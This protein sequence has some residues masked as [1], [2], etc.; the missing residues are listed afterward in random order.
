MGHSFLTIV[1]VVALEISLFALAIIA[2]DRFAPARWVRERH[3]LA[4]GG[5]LLLPVLFLFA[6][7]PGEQAPQIA[8]EP[9]AYTA[10]ATMAATIIPAPVPVVRESLPV[11]ATRPLAVENEATSSGF[12]LPAWEFLIAL[13]VA[14]AA[15]MLIR[16]G[17][18]LTLLNG[19]R[20]RSQPVSLP[21]TLHLSRAVSIRRSDEVDA[22]MVTG[23]LRPVVIVPVDFRFDGQA[24]CILEHEIAHITRGDAWSELLIRTLTSVFWWVLPLHML[25]AIVRRTRETLCDVH[26]V[27]VTGAPADLAHALL[28]A[29]SRAIRAPSL[30]LSAAPT[31]STLTARIDHLTSDKATPRRTIIMRMPF[32]LPAIA[33][34]AYAAT[35]QLGIAR[36]SAEDDKQILVLRDHDGDHDGEHTHIHIDDADFDFDFSE[37]EARLEDLD[38]SELEARL[39]ELDVEL[40]ARLAEI[41]FTE[42]EQKMAALE[43]EIEARIREMDFASLEADIQAQVEAL[44]LEQLSRLS[45]LESLIELEVLGKLGDLAE[46]EQLASLHAEAAVHDHFREQEAVY[47]AARRGDLEALQS[48]AAEGRDLSAA[49][50]GDGTPLMGA[51]RGGHIDVVTYLLGQGVDVNVRSPGDGTALITAARRDNAEMV[52]TLLQAGADANLGVPGDGNPLIGAAFMGNTDIARRLITAGADPDGYVPGDE[53]PLINAALMGHMEVAE[54]LVQAGADISLTVQAGMQYPDIVETYRSPLSE[55][56]RGGHDDMVAWLRSMGAEHRPPAR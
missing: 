54:M 1:G 25:H 30:A 10:P 26:S 42:F 11:L 32:V 43:V 33:V 47:N 4:L 19:L 2:F 44:E 20:R 12:S 51:I 9:I 31:R 36:E 40:E 34:L 28:D 56:E 41:D 55:A 22:P 15:L 8:P 49:S 3:N 52:E 37:L 17:Q 29:A 50:L 16:L 39:A 18:D 5:F 21:E 46:L 6:S 48:M 13:W 23:L 53:T 7:Q 45:E 38:F 27:D 24:Q 35:P 14:G